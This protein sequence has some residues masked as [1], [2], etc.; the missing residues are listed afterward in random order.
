MY[1]VGRANL[2]LEL[3]YTPD[4]V[5]NLNFDDY[6]D[7]SAVMNARGNQMRKSQG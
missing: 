6:N 1:R 7:I 4:E 3:H 2:I 5:D